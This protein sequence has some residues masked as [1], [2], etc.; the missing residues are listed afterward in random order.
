MLSGKKEVI[1]FFLLIKMKIGLFAVLGFLILSPAISSAE[2]STKVLF[3]DWVVTGTYNASDSTIFEVI[4]NPLKVESE[5]DAKVLVAIDNQT[6]IVRN[7]QCQTANHTSVCVYNISQSDKF[8]MSYFQFYYE[9]LITIEKDVP[10]LDLSMS[11]SQGKLMVNEESNSRIVIENDGVVAA[12]KLELKGNYPKNVEVLSAIG[13]EVHENTVTWKGELSPHA[14]KQCVV[15]IRGI[16][17]GNQKASTNLDYELGGKASSLIDYTYF[18]VESL[19]VKLTGKLTASELN[20]GDKLGLNLTYEPVY[21]MEWVKLKLFLPQGLKPVRLPNYWVQSGNMLYY[22]R[23]LDKKLDW[24]LAFVADYIG[25]FKLE[26]VAAYKR[27]NLKNNV[28]F[29]YSFSVDGDKLQIIADD[30]GITRN[31]GEFYV[32]NPSTTEFKKVIVNYTIDGKPG[33]VVFP[34]ILNHNHKSVEFEYSGNKTQVPVAITIKYITETGQE[35][36]SS[37]E[38][39]FNINTQE[40]EVWKHKSETTQETILE[41]DAPEGKKGNLGLTIWVIGLLLLF[42]VIGL[43]L[44]KR[45]DT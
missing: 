10:S 22:N 35:L 3:N 38:F 8:N 45:I 41:K 43:V 16:L 11:S 36:S 33:V 4:V 29:N 13:C 12:K 17:P 34:E 18:N 21:K 44:K 1:P 30:L 14:D 40:E 9:A 27:E 37:S 19:A 31:K 7:N 5:R 2:L 28:S 42:V 26:A 25:N 6:L 20:A 23:N 15:R 24:D 32:K 39:E